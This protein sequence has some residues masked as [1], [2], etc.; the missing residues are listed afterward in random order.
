MFSTRLPQ[1]D[2]RT[3][4]AG[5]AA[6]GAAALLSRPAQADIG[7]NSFRQEW[8]AFRSRFYMPE[9]RIADNYQNGASHSEGQGYAMLLAEAAG[10]TQS[11]EQLVTWTRANMRRPGDNLTPWRWRPGAA[12][13]IE[14]FNNA[15]D[16]DILIAWALARAGRSMGRPEYRRLAADIAR[17]VLRV[18]IHRV[19]DQTLLR[20]GGWGFDRPDHVVVNPSYL[21]F[22]ALPEMNQVAPDPAWE[23]LSRD[24]R[25]LLRA[26]RFG[27]WGLPPDWLRV[28]RGVGRASPAAGWE[29]RF[30]FDAVRVPLNMVWAGMWDEPA[31]DSAA[32]FWSDPS[33]AVP[34]AWTNLT[35]GGVAPYAAPAGMRAVARITVAARIGS[36]S[37]MAMPRVAEATDYYS[38][39]LT[40]L[41][42][43]AWRDAQRNR[44]LV[45]A[46]AG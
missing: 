23:R 24:G 14:D 17:D 33:V 12:A 40:M 22:A 4:L 15:S 8:A 36:T 35:S 42:R 39:V 19:G 45:V 5:L 26:A 6:G 9:G 30:G 20:P 46:S 34:P 27:S 1:A 32:A 16:G 28:P 37:A 7:D 11:F 18:C 2:R 21:I 29:P 44:P 25:S 43:L 13:P 10:D 3:V 41:A 31:V 38:A